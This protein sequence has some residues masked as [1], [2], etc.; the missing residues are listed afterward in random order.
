[1]TTR[2]IEV[3]NHRWP[4]GIRLV[5]PVPEAPWWRTPD[6]ERHEFRGV[7]AGSDPRS[8]ERL[9][10]V[11][12]EATGAIIRAAVAAKCAGEPVEA[13]RLLAG[14]SR[15]CQELLGPWAPRP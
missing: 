11:H 12:A 2:T 15:L 9:A 7:V 13:R 4:G 8:I 10:R 6:G 3:R 1:M 5:P 14:A